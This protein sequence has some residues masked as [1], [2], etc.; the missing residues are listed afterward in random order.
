MTRDYPPHGSE[1]PGVFIPI[2]GFSPHRGVTNRGARVDAAHARARERTTRDTGEDGPRDELSRVESSRVESSRVDAR[3]V[4][5]ETTREDE[6]SEERNE[7][8]R[9]FGNSP[10]GGQRVVTRVRGTVDTRVCERDAPEDS[11][12]P[13]EGA[14]GMARASRRTKEARGKA[15]ADGVVTLA[16]IAAQSERSL[17]RLEEEARTRGRG[18]EGEGSA[19]AASSSDDGEQPDLVKLYLQQK[20]GKPTESGAA[21]A[22]SASADTHSEWD[23]KFPGQRF[24]QWTKLEITA[25][26]DAI[27]QWAEEHGLGEAYEKGDYEFL[28][29]RRQKLGGK[30]ANLPRSERRAFIEISRGVSTR[31]A[32][33]IYGWILRNMNKKASKGKWTKDETEELLKQFEIHGPKWSKISSII[34]RPA[35]ACRDKWRLAKC[36]AERRTGHWSPEETLRLVQLVNGHFQKRGARPGCGPGENLEHLELRDNIPWKSISS[37]LR[38]RNEQACLQRWYQIAP[39]MTLVGSWRETQDFELL[40][41]IIKQNKPRLELLDWAALVN[42]RSLSHIKRRWKSL[43]S[44]IPGYIDMSLPELVLCMSQGLNGCPAALVEKAKVYAQV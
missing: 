21:R 11:F 38:T 16:D 37:E 3:R 27:K 1:S 2:L 8:R 13:G 5:R 34:G 9:R 33:Q 4:S 25:T 10:G 30:G 24:G 7:S 6:E 39:D 35:S 19:S 31:N 43:A 36:P 22:P 42:G 12:H 40:E 20:V 28:F 18:G 15:H 17:K 23:V 26:Q 32:K 14:R 44:K 29:E 41:N